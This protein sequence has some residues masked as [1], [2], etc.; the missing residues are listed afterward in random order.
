MRL[1]LKRLFSLALLLAVG[2]AAQAQ[3]GKAKAAAS[4]SPAA[5]EVARLGFVEGSVDVQHPGGAWTRAAENQPLM[6]G[7]RVRTS[8]GSTARLEFPWTAIA[9]GDGSEA[10]LQDNRVLTLQLERGRLD[11]DPEQTLLRVVTEEAAISGT[12]RTLVRR[13]G[14]STFVGSYNGGAEVESKGAVVR[15]GINKGTLVKAGSAPGEAQT[16]GPAPRVISP[17]MDPPYIRPGSPV[18]LTWQGREPAYHLEVLSIDSDVPVMSLDIDAGEFELRLNWL[19]MFRWRVAGR[20]GPVE[21][22][23]SGEGL[24]CVTEK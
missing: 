3:T 12:G 11:I 16:L 22:Q 19:G 23:P 24:I 14:K 13:E 7:D 21:S 10:G 17:S 15:L 20:N 1:E 9:M 18:R 2:G 8:R 4:P 6:I 5:L